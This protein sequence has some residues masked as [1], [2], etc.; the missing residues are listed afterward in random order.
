MPANRSSNDSGLIF[1]FIIIAIG[2]L[3]LLNKLGFFIPGWI[4][5]WPMILVAIGT[6]T[7]VK[8]GFRSFFGS[9]MLGLGLYFLF[10]REFG[11]DFGIER[12]IFPVALILLGLYFVTQRRKENKI[13]SDIDSQINKSMK[14][15]KDS[16]NSS[17]GG[18]KQSNPFTSAGSTFNDRLNIDAIFSGVDKRVMSKN[19]QGGK[20]T[21]AFGGIDIDF[22]QADFKGIATLQVD[23][24]FGGMKLVVPPHWDVRTEVSN[25]AAGV[26]D[27]RIYRDSEVDPEKVLL[28]RGTVLFGGLEIKSF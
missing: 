21:A 19:F 28:L 6:F 13:L 14:E 23:V 10:E 20:L 9:I 26:E 24:I 25:I 17:L 11:F 3:I 1:G 8:H 16:M 18:E 12:Y 2:V 27:K 5:S 7:L 15:A 22:T 4:L